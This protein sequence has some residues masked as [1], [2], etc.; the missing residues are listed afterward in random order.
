MPS[1]RISRSTTDHRPARRAAA[2][3][4][5]APLLL[6]AACGA[7]G[8]GRPPSAPG[9]IPDDYRLAAGRTLVIGRVDVATNGRPGFGPV[10]NPML[11]QLH[12]GDARSPRDAA[13]WTIPDLNPL[14]VDDPNAGTEPYAGSRAIGRRTRTGLLA[15]PVRPGSYD[16]LIVF[17]PDTARVDRPVESI[18]APDRPLTFA[19]LRLDPGRIVYV[20]DIEVAQTATWPDRLRDRIA[21]RYTVRDRFAQTTADFRARYPQFRDAAIEKHLL[22]A[23]APGS[24]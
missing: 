18:P 5:I 9:Q 7:L 13:D 4:V 1:S 20:G 16:G 24:P 14:S 23:T 2:A 19:P 12:P 10:T 22:A 6:L 11:L 15:L 21:M 17:Y 8:V 3:G